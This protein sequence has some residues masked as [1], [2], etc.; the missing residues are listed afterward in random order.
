ML[1]GLSNA[2]ARFL[3]YVMS[4]EGARI[5][6]IKT[7]P[8][9]K[10]VR[11]IQDSRSTHLAAQDELNNWIIRRLDPDSVCGRG[12]MR[13]VVE[14]DQHENNAKASGSEKPSFLTR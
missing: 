4:T 14:E 9:L 2:P 8:E 5:E 11:D 10:L 6:R 13:L 1:F 7:W 3:R 12:A